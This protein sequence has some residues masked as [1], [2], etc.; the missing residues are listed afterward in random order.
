MMKLDPKRLSGQRNGI[1][2]PAS[3]RVGKTRV[4]DKNLRRKVS[5]LVFIKIQTN[6]T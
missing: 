5:M 1:P 2:R 3:L 6:E 4:K